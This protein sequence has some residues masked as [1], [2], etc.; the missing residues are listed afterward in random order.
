MTAGDMPIGDFTY[1]VTT[2]LSV[3]GAGQFCAVYLASTNNLLVATASYPMMGILQDNPNGGTKAT[4]GS[5]REI[6]HSKCWVDASTIVAGSPLKVSS[7]AG[8]LGLGTLT[9]DIIVAVALEGNSSATGIIEVALTNRNASGISARAGHLVFQIPIKSLYTT[10]S[11]YVYEAMPLNFVGSVVDMFA[12]AN[13]TCGATTSSTAVL[14]VFLGAAGHTEVTGISIGVS[15]LTEAH[16]EAIGTV[17]TSTITT[18][19]ANSFVAADLMSIQVTKGTTSF[20][21][22]DTGTIEL[23]VV[24][25]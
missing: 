16:V 17:M 11:A 9:S 22:S 2:D 5:V 15:Q 4:V 7:T 8:K 24:T 21:A 20:G 10:S 1:P 23:H 3:A 14:K 12:I 18:L 25:N 13:S 19:G 6:G